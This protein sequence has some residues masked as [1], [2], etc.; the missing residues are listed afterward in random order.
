[1]I[2]L[3]GKNTFVGIIRWAD[4]SYHPLSSKIPLRLPSFIRRNNPSLIQTLIEAGFTPQTAYG[5]ISTAD[6]VFT[7]PAP[8]IHSATADISFGIEPHNLLGKIFPL[9]FRPT[10]IQNRT[11]SLK[12]NLTTDF[13]NELLSPVASFFEGRRKHAWEPTPEYAIQLT[14]ISHLQEFYDYAFVIEAHVALPQRIVIRAE[15]GPFVT[16]EVTY[17][18]PYSHW[19]YTRLSKVP[20][21]NETYYSPNVLTIRDVEISTSTGDWIEFLAFN[22]G[23]TLTISKE[24]FPVYTFPAVVETSGNWSSPSSYQFPLVEKEWGAV[25]QSVKEGGISITL[26]VTCYI[27]S[28]ANLVL[29]ADLF[30]GSNV[31]LYARQSFPL[32]IRLSPY[33]VIKANA[34]VSSITSSSALNELLRINAHIILT[35]PIEVTL[36]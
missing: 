29:S 25:V 15:D 28:D 24:I 22:Y 13:I 20:S 5:F 33:H 6:S 9:D 35:E 16:F 19:Y 7:V 18:T 17:F 10:P 30:G 21:Y 3:S 27:P 32:T 1:M 23:F 8:P 31:S 4:Y 11:I 36:Q 12:G 14:T 2:L 34:Q 26:D